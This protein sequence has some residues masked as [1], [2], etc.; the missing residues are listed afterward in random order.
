M[1]TYRC[2]LEKVATSSLLAFGERGVSDLGE[3]C[4]VDVNFGAGS[5]GVGLVDALNW[6]AVDLVGSGDQQES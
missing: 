4:A 2:V 3:I 6:N 5:D 1:V